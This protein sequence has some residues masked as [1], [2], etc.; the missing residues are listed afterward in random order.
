MKVGGFFYLEATAGF[1]P[2]DKGFAGLCLT[3]WPRR[4]AGQSRSG[5]KERQGKARLRRVGRILMER[6]TGIE[7]ATSTLARL[8]S[9]AELLPLTQPP[10]VPR[11][12]Q[13]NSR[14][15]GCQ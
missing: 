12:R 3:T 11:E 13:F 9:T 7:P 4:Q 15:R 2:A 8:H 14:I 1:E 6:E 5:L 10:A